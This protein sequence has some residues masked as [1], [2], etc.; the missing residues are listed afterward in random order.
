[1]TT[2]QIV[3]AE[4]REIVRDQLN[5]SRAM[6]QPVLPAHVDFDT[7]VAR[8][9]K[10]LYEHPE[11]AEC[12]TGSLFWAFVQASEVGLSVGG[13]FGEGFIIPFGSPRNPNSRKKARFVPG[14]KGL[15]KLAYQ[16]PLVHRI[17]A[18]VVFEKDEF[19][20]DLGTNSVRYVPYLG[21]DDPGKPI[22]AYTQIQLAS[23]A[24]KHD[25]MP[26]WALERIRKS[27]PGLRKSDHPW[28]THPL[29]MYRKTGLRHALKDAPKA[30]EVD[31]AIE[32]A[33][34][35]DELSESADAYDEVAQLPGFDDDGEPVT[36]TDQAKARIQARSPDP[37]PQSRSRGR[38]RNQPSPQPVQPSPQP[39]QASP[40]PSRASAK[41]EESAPKPS[42][43][44]QT[45]S[46]KAPAATVVTQAPLPPSAMDHT[47]TPSDNPLPPA[48]DFADA[49]EFFGLE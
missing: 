43:K 16:S 38:P 20:P 29:E 42:P 26:M 40:Q 9:Y 19:V 46:T 41:A 21:Q 27:A 32:Q 6:I 7:C 5:D 30:S 28:N 34:R 17:D 39:V 24:V 36:R 22:A 10:H 23:G 14:Y 44:A 49:D 37:A 8:M 13:F 3:R 45:T 2:T 31:R 47:P 11:L 1:M 4:T 33:L 12:T 18:F 48:E 35:L 15:V 25:V